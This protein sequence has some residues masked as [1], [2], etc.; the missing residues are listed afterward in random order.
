MYMYEYV[1]LSLPY[2]TVHGPA[3]LPTSLYPKRSEN[4]LTLVG[5]MGRKEEEEEAC[6]KDDTTV[7]PSLSLSLS[8]LLN[9][10]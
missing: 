3:C 7:R 8:F 4:D 9:R 5:D 6:L 2:T 10:G 1:L